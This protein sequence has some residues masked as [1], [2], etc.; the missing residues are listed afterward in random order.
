VHFIVI[1]FTVFT[2][3]RLTTSIKEISCDD[4]DDD[5][6]VVTYRTKS[7]RAEPYSLSK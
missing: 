1:L 2:E 3:L 6:R 5:A 7:H 4:D